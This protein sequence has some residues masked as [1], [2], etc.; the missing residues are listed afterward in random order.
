[1]EYKMNTSGNIPK[2]KAS[3]ADNNQPANRE[4][5][6]VKTPPNSSPQH[7]SEE[8]GS[9][10]TLEKNRSMTHLMSSELMQFA[11]KKESALDVLS[12]TIQNNN[13]ATITPIAEQAVRKATQIFLSNTEKFNQLIDKTIFLLGS[14]AAPEVRGAP[15]E[16]SKA[17]HLGDGVNRILE[18][19]ESKVRKNF[20]GRREREIKEL[21]EKYNNLVLEEATSIDRSLQAGPST[22]AGSSSQETENPKSMRELMR[23]RAAKASM[24]RAHQTEQ[25]KKNIK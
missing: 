2:Q 8:M 13:N 23:E 10:D 6:S 22:R 19:I 7:D 17:I 20:S 25:N 4:L 15:N 24:A 18:H 12:K 21:V 9:E 3:V 14:S 1:M 16:R 5:S 11:I